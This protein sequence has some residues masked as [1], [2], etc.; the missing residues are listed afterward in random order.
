MKRKNGYWTL[1]KCKKEAKKYKTRT[2][3]A[4]KSPS[5]YIKSNKEAWLEE[6]SLHMIPGR[7]PDNYWTKER[8]LENALLYTVKTRWLRTSTGAAIASQKKGWFDECTKHM[9]S[10]IKPMGYWTKER[11]IEESKKYKTRREWFENAGGSVNSAVK[12]GWVEE[13]SLHM[14]QGRK[15]S[16]YWTKE[17][18]IESAQKFTR[19]IDWR[20]NEKGAVNASFQNKWNN[21]CLKH[22][23]KNK[24]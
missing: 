2:E 8:C 10:P 12:N 20:N 14:I 3:W 15:P 21:D 1:D 17:K 18:C 11:C 13:C 4:K 7:K 23:R 6:C 5:S 24:K 16:G 9:I 19:F 22:M